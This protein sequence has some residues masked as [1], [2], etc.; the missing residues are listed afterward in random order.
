MSTSKKLEAKL[1]TYGSW[2]LVTGAS[3]G[4]GKALAEKVAESGLNLVLVGRKNASSKN[5]VEAVAAF[6]E[7]NYGVRTKIIYAD[8]SGSKDVEHLLHE[9]ERLDIGLF[10]ASAGFG[11]SGE[12]IKSSLSDELNMLDVNCKALLIL[13]HH[14]A[15]SFAARGKG[16]IILLSSMVA[17]QG[18]PYAGHYA[19]TK[20]YVQSLGE[21]LAHE[22]RPLNVDVLAAAPGPVSTGFESRA[23]MKMGKT[24]KPEEIST[25][26]LMALGKKDT[27]LP[28]W[29]TKVLVT[30]LR[31]VPRWGKVIIMKMVMGGMTKHQRVGN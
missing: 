1:N 22:L 21:A 2:A 3:S 31:T 17:F 5:T 18:V 30:G 4:I 12:L 9:V 28:G 16:G 25:E 26:I 23:N 14:F 7:A 13:T 27:I 11:T 29:L 6:L 15:K 24:L 10:I 20:A 8:L 19:A